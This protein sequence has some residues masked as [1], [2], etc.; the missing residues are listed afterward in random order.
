[1]AAGLSRLVGALEAVGLRLPFSAE[2][3]RSLADYT[4]WASAEK[5]TRELGWT[6]RPVE[7]TLC[8]A[9]EVRRGA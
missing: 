3:L 6:H 7:E 4:F 5:A 9:L 1:M 8:E 2:A